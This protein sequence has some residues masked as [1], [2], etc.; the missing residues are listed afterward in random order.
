M[1]FLEILVSFLAGQGKAFLQTNT[2]AVSRRIA[3]NARRVA[4]LLAA[5]IVSIIL[6]CSGVEMAYGAVVAAFEA[7]QGW[8]WSPALAGGLLLSAVAGYGLVSSLSEKRW[9]KAVGANEANN[10]APKAAGPSPVESAVA[11]LLLEL[12]DQLRARREAAPSE[13]APKDTSSV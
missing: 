2:E 8:S 6:F 9:M 1:K 12:S 11:V 5:A 10:E 3:N 7:G 13:S 4:A